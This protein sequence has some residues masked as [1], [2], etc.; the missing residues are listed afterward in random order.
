MLPPPLLLLHSEL[1]SR[2]VGIVRDLKLRGRY[3]GSLSVILHISV[4][5]RMMNECFF[6]NPS[7]VGIQ[8]FGGKRPHPV[9]T[10]PLM[11]LKQGHA[12]LSLQCPTS[13]NVFSSRGTNSHNVNLKYKFLSFRNNRN[14]IFVRDHMPQSHPLWDMSCAGP[15]HQS[16]FKR[17]LESSMDGIT[18]ILD[19]RV[20]THDEGLV[21]VRLNTLS[22]IHPSQ[23]KLKTKI[24]LKVCMHDGNFTVLCRV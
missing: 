16:I 13:R 15:P 22:T 19:R 23:L 24:A 8:I 11:V 20:T 18:D 17:L 5:Q 21:E 4:L 2:S 9:T 3:V 1:V 10:L 14:D 6:L 12:R 7:L